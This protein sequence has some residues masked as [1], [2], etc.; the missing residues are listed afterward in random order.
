M[1]FSVT[2]AHAILLI[3]GLGAG[4]AFAAAFLGAVEDQATGDSAATKAAVRARETELGVV[5]TG[6]FPSYNTGSDRFKVQILND[7]PVPV[8]V[9]RLTHV[10]DGTVMTTTLIEKQ[11]VVA[12]PQ[13]DLLLPGETLEVWFRPIDPSPTRYLVVTADGAAAGWWT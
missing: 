4:G 13:S 11:E 2:A 6:G 7:G 3:A 8:E 12:D 9:S 1:G 5:E 10:V